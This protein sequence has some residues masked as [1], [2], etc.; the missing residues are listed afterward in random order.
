[1]KKL[2]NKVALITGAA[3]GMGKAIALLFAREGGKLVISDIDKKSLRTVAD[4]IRADG[5]TVFAL[6]GDIS[7]EEAVQNMVDAAINNYGTVDILVNNAGIMDNFVPAAEVDDTLWERVLAVN[8]TGPMRLIRKVLPIMT[9]KQTGSIVNI[10]S[11][12]GLQGSRAGAA[13]TSSKHALIGL[14]KNVAFQYADQGIR[15]NAIAPGGVNTNIGETFKTPNSFGIGKAMS[16]ATFN[17]RSGEPEEIAT[18]A[19]FLASEEASFVNG[20]VITADGGWT[21]Y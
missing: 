12:G 8:L 3:A 1:M 9:A 6:N 17:P 13:Y 7:K 2:E 20:A 15:C 16:G 11:I 5:G 10:A 14:T 4:L 21:A 18:I 19:S